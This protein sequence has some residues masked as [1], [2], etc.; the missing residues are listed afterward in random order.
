MTRRNSKSLSAVGTTFFTAVVL[1]C[2][3]AAPASAVEPA[4]PLPAAPAVQTIKGDILNIEGEHVVVKDMSGHEV[5]MHVS[6]DTHMDRVKVGDK[7]NATVRADGHA[8][9]LQVQLPQ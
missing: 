9:S 2:C 6:K 3:G 1:M 8:E 5:R 7:V 4:P